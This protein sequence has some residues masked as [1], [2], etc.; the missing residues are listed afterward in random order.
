VEPRSL[1]NTLFILA[2]TLCLV[3]EMVVRVVFLGSSLVASALVVL[4]VAGTAVLCLWYA[5]LPRETPLTGFAL[6]CRVVVTTQ[7]VLSA[8]ELL[9]SENLPLAYRWGYALACLALSVVTA[10]I[11]ERDLRLV[12][13]RSR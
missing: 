12:L 10:F 8:K 11:L 6:L 3:L 5:S 1:F 9:A 13:G 4:F 7:V 2:L